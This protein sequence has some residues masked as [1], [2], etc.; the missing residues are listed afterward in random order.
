M[1]VIVGLT[2]K[3]IACGSTWLVPYTAGGFLYIALVSIVPDLLEA[4]MGTEK[5]RLWTV[6]VLWK[7]ELWG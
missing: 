2:A 3:Q 6:V 7:W 4:G 5:K 1:G